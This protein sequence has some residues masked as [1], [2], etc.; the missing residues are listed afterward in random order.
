MAW[1]TWITP[2]LCPGGVFTR[3]CQW[4]SVETW[5]PSLTTDI[6]HGTAGDMPHHFIDL[7]HF[8]R[9]GGDST[10]PHVFSFFHWLN[11]FNFSFPPNF[12][13]VL[14]S[15]YL[16]FYFSFVTHPLSVYHVHWSVLESK[17]PTA[18]FPSPD[19][20]D[21]VRCVFS[22]DFSGEGSHMFTAGMRQVI[23]QVDGS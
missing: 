17:T 19:R 7:S 11:F 22:S 6:T 13:C 8:F 16:T 15:P 21:P 10:D 1:I 23:G 18:G 12:L 4:R 3:M 9:K 20:S 2:L 14:I 5:R